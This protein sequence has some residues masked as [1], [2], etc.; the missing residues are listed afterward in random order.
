MPG[1]QEQRFIQAVDQVEFLERDLDHVTGRLESWLERL[2]GDIRAGGPARPGLLDAHP[3]AVQTDEIHA[4]LQ[5]SWHDWA[6]QWAVLKP[7]QALADTFDDKVMLLVFG[8]FN[9]GKSSF[10]NFLAER[11]TG[12]GKSVRYFWI[13]AGQLVESTE[14][15]K[16]GATETTSALQGV[17][18]GEKLLLLDTPGLHSVTP[19]NAALTQRYTDSADGVLW[20][21]SSTS[22]GQVQELDEL[23]RELRRNKPLLPVVTRSDFIDEDEVDGEICKVLCNKSA[24]N[25]ELQEQ[26]VHARAQDKLRQMEVDL[27][28]LRPPVSISSHAARSAGHTPQAMRAAGFDRLYEALLGIVG[29]ALR[30]KQRQPAEM[31]LHHFEENV[32]GGLFNDSLPRLAELTAGLE[33]ES[34]MLSQ[35]KARLAQ[36]L[37]REVAPVLP[38]LLQ[39]H[40]RSGGVQAV[41]EALSQ[42]LSESFTRQQALTFDG[43]ILVVDPAML[44]IHPGD[45]AWG[46]TTEPGRPIEDAE[47]DSLYDSLETTLRKRLDD[48]V[49]EVYRQCAGYLETLALGVQD[50]R[51]MLQAHAHRLQDV[52]RDLRA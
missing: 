45:D 14:A 23:G 29:P 1:R 35:R 43:Y 26:D 46:G 15:F 11:F 50:T 27:S 25:R 37:W 28:A 40:A 16:E 9:A 21:T 5:Q 3:L 13:H 48:L 2:G 41:C 42:V 51:D 34:L 24:T 52:K 33:A 8:K 44:R 12:Q 7:A 20:L 30:Y 17:V 18:L 6:Q 10:C 22:P 49:I 32:L 4:H 39:T 47:L 19:E 31:L 36:G 38:E